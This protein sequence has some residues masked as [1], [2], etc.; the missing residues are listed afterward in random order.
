MDNYIPSY[1]P[2]CE[3]YWQAILTQ[4]PL[5]TG[6]VPG[7]W[8]W[9]EAPEIPMEIWDEAR[10]RQKH[11]TIFELTIDGFNRGGVI[12]HWNEIECFVPASHLIAYPFPADPTCS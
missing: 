1:S 10:E 9:I 11:H 6:K 12:A 4:G 5:S 3:S 7:P 2:P 8:E